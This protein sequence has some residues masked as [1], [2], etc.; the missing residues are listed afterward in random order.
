ML[1]SVWPHPLPSSPIKGEVPSCAWGGI[2]TDTT[3]PTSPLMGE[4]GRGWGRT[5]Q[6]NV[7]LL[8]P[9]EF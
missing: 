9:D 2:G 1:M 7:S 8:N 3:A 6:T 5:H 4:A